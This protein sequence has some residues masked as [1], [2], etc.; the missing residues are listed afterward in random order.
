MPASRPPGRPTR[1]MSPTTPPKKAQL[2]TELLQG[3]LDAGMT[4]AD[5]ARRAHYSNAALSQATSGR[6]IPT[7]DLIK[8]YAQAVG[9][10]EAHWLALRKEAVEEEIRLRSK[11]PGGPETPAAGT[12]LLR[13]AH[14]SDVVLNTTGRHRTSL[15]RARRDDERAAAEG[16]SMTNERVDRPRMT[17]L[18]REAV[19][20]AEHASV[21]LHGD[22]VHGALSLCTM[23]SD[24]MDLLRETYLTSELGL[25]EISRR[26]AQHN[27]RISPSSLS[28]LLNGEQ[29]PP[30]GAL[31]AVLAACDVPS[32]Q[33]PAWLY[34]RARLE[35]AG[36]RHTT[37]HHAVTGTNTP[38]LTPMMRLESSHR[39]GLQLLILACSII[40]ATLPIL[41][42]W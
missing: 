34:H 2:A 18:V 19:Q 39:N 30:M 7:P 37:G 3:R 8:A 17:E 33:I 9:V 14:P 24:L 32:D 1:G 11:E 21:P 22:P 38:T 10:D 27:V 25:R 35:I 16:R 41:L 42:R 13:V 36:V 23:P 20:T 40:A 5:V 31:A 28:T 12:P 15:S 26:A 29:L 4:L 6:T